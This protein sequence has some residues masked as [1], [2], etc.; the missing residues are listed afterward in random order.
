MKKTHLAVVVLPLTLYPSL[1]AESLAVIPIEQASVNISG[2]DGSPS[3]STGGVGETIYIRMR[4][5]SANAVRNNV[6][7]LRFDLS[8]LETTDIIQTASLRFNKV[9]GDTANEGRVAIFGLLDADGNLAQDWTA[10]TFAYGAEF[11]PAMFNDGASTPGASPVNLS[12]VADFSV[13][14]SIAGNT[15]T[16]SGD[17]LEAFLQ[18]RVAE[19]GMVTF[20][21]T[22]P[23]QGGSNDKSYSLASGTY[24]TDETLR[25]TLEVAFSD[26]SLPSP[27]DGLSTSGINYSADPTL[28]IGWDPSDGAISYQVY[29]RAADEEEATLLDTTASTSFF[30]DDVALYG[31]YFYTVSVTTS[32]GTSVTTTEHRVE[33]RDT[34]AGLPPAPQGF[35]TASATPSTV[36]ITWSPAPGAFLYDVYR[37]IHPDRDFSLV[38]TVAAPAYTDS[39]VEGYRSYY[40]RV[41]TIGAGGISAAS[42]THEVGPRFVSGTLPAAPQNLSLVGNTLYST[43]LSWDAV[44][45][46]QAYY[47]Y[48]STRANDGYTLVGITESNSL[49][50]TYAVMPQNAYYYQV[51]TAGAAGLSAASATF[52]VDATLHTYR[53]MENITRAPVAVPSSGGMLVSWRLLGT[54]GDATSFRIYRDGQRLNNTPITG[55]TNHFDPNGTTASTYEVRTV[56][57]AYEIPQGEIARVLENGYHSVPIQAP[58][59]GTTPLN[60][61]YSY[62]ANDASVGDLDGDGE[63]EIVLKWD[64]TNAKDN[65]QD[66]YTGNVYLDAYELDG[67]QLWRIDL[68]RNI[69]A[70]AH[71]TQFMVYDLDGDGMA[72]VVCKT[73]DATI[74]GQGTVIGDINADYRR[75]DGYILEGPEYYTAFRGTDG[76]IIDTI[77]YVPQR[78]S[79][80][81]WGDTYGNRV[82]R[83]NAGIAYFDGVRPSVYAA[84]GYYGGQSG[85]GPGRTVIAA[86]DLINGELVE[87]WVFDTEVDGQQYIAQGNHQTSVGDVDGDGKDEL[88]HGSI[89]F[90]DDGSVLWSSGL[91]HG[92]AM[93]YGDLIPGRPGMELFSV[94]ESGGVEFHSVMSDAATGTTIWGVFNGS[95]TGRGLSADIDP[96][97]AGSES[98]G[99]A[100]LNVWAASGEVIGTV[101][102]SINFSI[103]WDGDPLSELM[104]GNSVRKWDWVNQTEVPLLIAD[105]ASSNNG[106]KA[107][108]A[109]QADLMGDWREE[110][111]LRSNDNTELRI[112]STPYPTTI[113]IPTLMHDPTYRVA[114]AWQNSA[115]NQ[116]P[117]PSFFIGHD[118][119]AVAMPD[120]FTDPVPELVGLMDGGSY[121]TGVRVILNANLRS[122]LR[123]EYRVD[124]G[125]WADYVSSFVVNGDGAH[126]VEFR[127]YD[128][129]DNLLASSSTE[130]TI[131]TSIPGDL[132]GDND[133][134]VADRNLL[135]ASLRRCEGQPGYNPAADLD[136][137]GCVDNVDYA[138]W[139]GYYAAFQSQP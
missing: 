91:G 37:S 136:D 72:E 12:N 36:Q 127:T 32:A 109:L 65:A 84:R 133:V 106:S 122:P 131:D 41:R 31:V 139:R 30:D 7:Y 51:K 132:D 3:I 8:S 18:D 116:P 135:L 124:G 97:Y 22:M 87:R 103:Y 110:V 40:Y 20:L 21:I 80:T 5:F 56:L 120:I 99:A 117:H 57:G 48:R 118:M 102:P 69:R 104:D 75:T 35:A 17:E 50:D 60:D 111:M 78:G 59:G 33:V 92:D 68:G 64:P 85:Q 43:E 63:Y 26:A 115:Y 79:L 47:V 94:K 128:G 28:T 83:F 46:A 39:A 11:D 90:D 34:N 52:G 89:T 126:T 96:N 13:L 108:P 130:F 29:R 112:Y 42:A 86:F 45:G 121:T 10:G 81:V 67:T 129:D 88:M 27:P 16:L 23:S 71:Y 1:H 138:L 123:N 6:A 119:P 58:P 24:T 77:D 76:S 98:W 62:V 113:R 15:I 19:G 114:V 82:D 38:D 25:P 61:P 44:V 4:D 66:G 74:D 49:N 134:D 105:G 53:Q 73:A 9:S 107:T 95:D 2:N 101:R 137:N 70:G 54:D 93:H 125:T 100:N 55:A 14:E